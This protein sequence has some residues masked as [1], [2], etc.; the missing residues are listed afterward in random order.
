VTADPLSPPFTFLVS[1][2]GGLAADAMLDALAPVL[3]HL[4]SWRRVA[5]P[6]S[7]LAQ[8]A[9]QVEAAGTTAVQLAIGPLHA[10]YLTPAVPT[11]LLPVW[12]FPDIPQ[13]D[14]F[15]NG[16]MNWARVASRAD[17][18]LA[19]SPMIANAFR[20]AG[21]AT[22]VALFPLPPQS[23]W[24][25]L[26]TWGMDLPVSIDVPHLAWG[27][28]T[29][30]VAQSILAD[31]TALNLPREETAWRGRVLTMS[32]KRLRTLKLYFSNETIQMLD[33]YKRRI[34]PIL[35]RP[36][37]IHLVGKIGRA[38]YRRFV[39]RWVS[40]EGHSKLKGLKNRLSGRRSAPLSPT[41]PTILGP[42]ALRLSGLIYSSIIDYSDAT[43]DDHALI[44]AAIHAFR[45]RPDI[46][47]LFRIVTTPEREASDLGRLVAACEAP[48][49]AYRCR[50]VVI[51]GQPTSET[52][53]A[54]GRATSYHVETSRSRGSAGGL[55]EALASGR[56]AISPAHSGY[57]AWMSD[58]VGYPLQ[59]NPEPSSWPLD[60][61]GRH[62][63]TWNRVVWSD[64]RDR[65]VESAKVATDDHRRYETMSATARHNI[66]EALGFETV[67][68]RLRTAMNLIAVR[69]PGAFDWS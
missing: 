42:S 27:G 25:E 6:E 46:T 44:S 45:D 3:E 69:T 21:V 56:P 54:I 2:A 65:L 34:V 58:D 15:G 57:A 23:G 62:V 40:E 29:Q 18:I 24:S 13:T 37:P 28:E 52:L 7:S 9:S 20:D 10:C 55:I 11:I 68:E 19:S 38:G 61:H 35:R 47:M 63:T 12:D 14:L 33:G 30:G 41:G 39:G 22:P 50:M 51:T 48:R 60:P 5:H 1:T 17:L 43:I 8:I 32:R 66:A 49:I 53:R 36:N 16:R 67:V 31:E 59:S 26:P 64:L 4:G